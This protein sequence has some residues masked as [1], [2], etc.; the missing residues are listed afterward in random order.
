MSAINTRVGLRSGAGEE[1]CLW[2]RRLKQISTDVTLDLQVQTF[3]PI[4]N[5]IH[6]FQASTHGL[7][8]SGTQ[9]CTRLPRLEPTELNNNDVAEF[10]GD[11]RNNANGVYTKCSC[12]AISNSSR[13]SMISSYLQVRSQHR[14]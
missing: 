8:A 12:K 3:L 2:A 10:V 4:F 5:F 6:C 14:L 13:R 1:A 11:I 7:P 9:R